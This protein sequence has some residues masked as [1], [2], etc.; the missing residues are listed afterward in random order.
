MTEPRLNHTSPAT[1]SEKKLPWQVSRRTAEVAT[2][3]QSSLLKALMNTTRLLRLSQRRGCTS[4][5]CC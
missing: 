1:V 3:A 2:K 4:M 5:D